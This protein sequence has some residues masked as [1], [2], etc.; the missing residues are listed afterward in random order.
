VCR[1]DLCKS[2][3]LKKILHIKFEVY[4]FVS[5]GKGPNLRV[6]PTVGLCDIFMK[7]AQSRFEKHESLKVNL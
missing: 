6:V 5:R 1:Y 7:E 3:K 4:R 2:L